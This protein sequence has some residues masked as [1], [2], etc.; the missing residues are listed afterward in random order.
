MCP[1]SVRRPS[2]GYDSFDEFANH[3]TT[4]RQPYWFTPLLRPGLTIAICCWPEH[5][6][7]LPTSCSGSWMLQHELWA[8]RRSTTAAWHT[9]FTLNCICSVWQIESHTSLGWRCTS[10]CMA[11]HRIICQSCLHQSLKLLNDS[12]FFPPATIYSLFHGFSS[13]RTAVAPSLSLDQRHGTCSK[14]ICVSRTCKLTVFVIHWR[15]VFLISTRH[16]ECIRGAFCDDALYK[17]TFTIF[18]NHNI[19]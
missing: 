6:S 13:I 2:T 8:A 18:I 3:S 10:A 12:I 7:L 14:T 9:C 17:L 11:R 4:N 16:I 15:H 5:Q 19:Q 1:S